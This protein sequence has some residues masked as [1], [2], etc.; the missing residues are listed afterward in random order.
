[1]LAA[2]DKSSLKGAWSGYVN[3]L[4]LVDINRSL[5]KRLYACRICQ[6]PAHWWQMAIKRS[7]VRVA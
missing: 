2:D 3:H 5:M 4:N 7:V 1:V 6:V